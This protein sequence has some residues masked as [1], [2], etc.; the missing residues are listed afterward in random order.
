MV[1][2]KDWLTLRMWTHARIIKSNGIMTQIISYFI[3]Y[4]SYVFLVCEGT[5]QLFNF[6]DFSIVDELF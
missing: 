6:V 2:Y 5:Q 3:F 4:P 1:K